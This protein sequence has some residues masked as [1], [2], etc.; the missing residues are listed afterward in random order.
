MTDPDL[1]ADIRRVTAEWKALRP[2][3]GFE[4]I[5]VDPPW[6]FRS[7]SAARPGRNARAHYRCQSLDWIKALPVRE[8]LAAKD[9]VVWLW[10]TNPFLR[11]AFDVLDAWGCPYSTKGEWVKTTKGGGLAFGTGYTFR[12]CDEPWLISRIGRPKTT[13]S[14]RSVVFG[15]VREHSRKPEEAYAAAEALL[16]GVRRIDV[17]SRQSRPGWTA[18]GDQSGTF[19]ANEGVEA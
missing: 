13:R 2:A 3:G 16:P 7:N 4:L 1:D 8:V 9:A 12:N 14:V 15:Q 6:N 11:I 5:M 10:T 18:W 19:D 17:F